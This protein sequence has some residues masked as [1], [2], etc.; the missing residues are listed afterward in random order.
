MEVSLHKIWV[1]PAFLLAAALPAAA[2]PPP[3]PP[4]PPRPPPL[5]LPGALG[6]ASART[7]TGTWIVAGRPS[8][9]TARIARRFEGRSLVPRGGVYRVRA[10]AAR[11]FAGALR[12]AGLLAFAER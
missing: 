12:A 10:A 5:E 3:A 9:R 1:M 4:T 6:A 2:T 7:S 8:P 11:P